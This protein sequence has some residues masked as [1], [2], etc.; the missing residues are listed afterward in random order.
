[1]QSL[2]C[3][4]PQQLPEPVGQPLVLHAPDE[5]SEALW[6]IAEP[7]KLKANTWTR[8]PWVERC[9][10]FLGIEQT[11]KGLLVDSEPFTTLMTFEINARCESVQDV[12]QWRL[13]GYRGRKIACVTPHAS[14]IRYADIGYTGRDKNLIR[15]WSYPVRL[16]E[17]SD[18]TLVPQVRAKMKNKDKACTIK[19]IVWH[20]NK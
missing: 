2:Y 20:F 11:Q 6:D 15:A 3:P 4:A 16:G 5:Y 19:N 7:V 17:D 9:N 13:V 12:L 1:M 18:V 14:S 10:T 8:L